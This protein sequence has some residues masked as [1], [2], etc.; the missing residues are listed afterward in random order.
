MYSFFFLMIR[1]PPKSTRTY[2]LFPYTTLFRSGI[3]ASTSAEFSNRDAFVLTDG[4]GANRFPIR[5]GTDGAS[6][7]APLTAAEVRALLEE[8]F[9]VMSRARAQIRRPL[10]SRAQVSISIVDTNGAV[11]GLVRA[12]DAPI[13][14]TDVRLRKARTATRSE[15]HTSELQ[16]LMRI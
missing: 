5:A 16:S 11:L 4:S 8:A 9:A 10:D 12:P 3:R 1:R 7:S 2:T 13:F 6:N 14:G 15:E